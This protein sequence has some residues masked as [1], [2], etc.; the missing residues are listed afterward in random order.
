MVREALHEPLRTR[1]WLCLDDDSVGLEEGKSI[2][3]L[4]VAFDTSHP[5]HRH[6]SPLSSMMGPGTIVREEV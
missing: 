3:S 4:A 6:L 2:Q 5:L 1:E